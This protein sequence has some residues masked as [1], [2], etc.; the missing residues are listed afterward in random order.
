MTPDDILKK[1][2]DDMLQGDEQPQEVPAAAVATTLPAPAE[3]APAE[4][5]PLA[6]LIGRQ[7]P[8]ADRDPFSMLLDDMLAQEGMS[9]DTEQAE[10]KTQGFEEHEWEFKKEVQ[11][12]DDLVE[13]VCK[14]CFR[15]MRMTR[16]QTTNQAMEAHQINPDCGMGV[17]SEV[18]DS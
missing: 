10:R 13:V 17:A 18:M 9:K 11:Y 16:E 8:D 5:D 7:D 4:P 6:H 1:Q 15:Q 14:K 2:L 3:E 12:E